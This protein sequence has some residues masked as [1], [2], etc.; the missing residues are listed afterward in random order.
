MSKKQQL[1]RFL[2]I[3]GCVAACGIVIALLTGT[4]SVDDGAAGAALRFVAN[5]VAESGVDAFAV[6][7]RDADGWRFASGD[8]T[9]Q[10]RSRSDAAEPRANAAGV[11]ESL[12]FGATFS[13][14]TPVVIGSTTVSFTALLVH[15]L[16]INL[17]APVVNYL[18]EVSFTRRDGL[19]SV[20]GAA[21]GEPAQHEG[22]EDSTEVPATDAVTVRMLMQQTSGIPTDA[23]YDGLFGGSTTDELISDVP[24]VGTPGE[25][26]RY[27]DRNYLILGALIE[28]ATGKS[29]ADVLNDRITA[30][31]GMAS[32]TAVW[33]PGRPATPHTAVFGI[34]VPRG[35][36]EPNVYTTAGGIVSCASDLARYLE[37]YLAAAQLNADRVPG[38]SRRGTPIVAE[39]IR[40]ALEP[41]PTVRNGTCYA[42]G[43]MV[44]TEDGMTRYYLAGDDPSFHTSLGFVP[45]QNAAFVFVTNTNSI[46]QSVYLQSVA[47]ALFD[48]FRGGEYGTVAFPYRPFAL[49]VGIVIVSLIVNDLFAFAEI[50]R[51]I[52]KFSRASGSAKAKRRKLLMQT[53]L[54]LL[55]ISLVALVLMNA[56]IVV[57]VQS[58]PDLTI[59]LFVAAVLFVARTTLTLYGK[60]RALQRR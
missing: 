47:T 20:S 34:P 31:L 28:A 25:R 29:Y 5:A 45:E 48:R 43:W 39:T 53:L 9:R 11:G 33:R 22:H 14:C 17:D 30:P 44:A 18:P 4:P 41:G 60:Y 40:A 58:Q 3:L 37:P 59:S 35:K 55:L 16:G 56:P 10:D 19:P 50:N 52:E 8:R 51:R 13:E 27:S 26:F 32:T 6:G 49:L 42:G 36:A 12:W 24:I 2:A 46:L 1:F 54:S 21:V 15:D 7:V 57:L 23:G 38:G